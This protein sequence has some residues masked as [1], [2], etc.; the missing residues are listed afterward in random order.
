MKVE[1]VSSLVLLFSTLNCLYWV[2]AGLTF[3]DGPDPLVY[4]I[5]SAALLINIVNSIVFLH[6]KYE[7]KMMKTLAVAFCL[8]AAVAV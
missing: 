1:D 6:Y 2:I 5:N 7:K 4:G 8:I 3:D